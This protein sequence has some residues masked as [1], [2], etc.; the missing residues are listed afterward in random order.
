[1]AFLYL[2]GIPLV[3]LVP[4]KPAVLWKRFPEF[5]P[6]CHHGLIALVAQ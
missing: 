5:K 2:L 3:L 4:I 1:M 6:P